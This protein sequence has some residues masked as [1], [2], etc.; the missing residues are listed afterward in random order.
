MQRLSLRR[1]EIYSRVTAGSRPP[2][3]PWTTSMPYTGKPYIAYYAPINRYPHHSHPPSAPWTTSMPY[4]GK[5]YI[6]YYAPINRYPHHSVYR[7]VEPE[8]DNALLDI[9]WSDPMPEEGTEDMLGMRV[10][11]SYCSTRVYFASCC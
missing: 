4:T 3:A 8:A 11:V 9:L 5:P 2:S 1:M 7:F 6:A 10:G